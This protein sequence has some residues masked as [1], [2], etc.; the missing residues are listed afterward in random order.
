MKKIFLLLL[1]LLL[2]FTNTLFAADGDLDTTFSTDG[3]VLH[4]FNVAANDGAI[5]VLLQ[6]DGKLIVG[7]EDSGNSKFSI[8]RFNTDG[9]LDTTFGTNGT[10][11]TD[12]TAGSD[13]GLGNM[14]FQSDGKIIQV[15]TCWADGT[16][17]DSC[18]VRYDANGTLDT[19][20][21]SSGIYHNS[22]SLEDALYD[23]AL[24]S[25]GKIL[26]GGTAHLSGGTGTRDF[27]LTRLTTSGTVDTSF[28]TSGTVTTSLGSG[29]D[30]I[31]RILIL[32]DGKILTVGVSS[33]NSN[34]FGLVKYDANG[35]IDT[36]FGT[37]GIVSTDFNGFG[38]SAVS[39]HELSDGKIL[40]AGTAGIDGSDSDFALIKYDSNGSID[41][42]FGTSGQVIIDTGIGA[43]A[44]V[45]SIIQNDG[46]ILIAGWITDATS[47]RDFA[48]VKLN[49]DGTLDTSFG[50]NGIVQTDI[51]SN[52]V[53]SARDMILQDDGK[54]V[55]VG[56]SS[57]N[58]DND[59]AIVRYE[60][61]DKIL[62]LEAHGGALQLD[63]T[64]Y[65][66]L[67]SR[68]D[69]RTLGSYGTIELWAYKN[70]WSVAN[71][72]ESLIS[73]TQ[74]SGYDIS[75]SGDT[76]TLN[77][78][79]HISGAYHSVSIDKTTIPSGWN[80][81][82]LSYNGSTISMYLNGQEQ[83]TTSASGSITDTTALLET[84]IGASL[85]SPL[86]SARNF[87]GLV[88]EV[89]IWN[90]ARSAS[91]I[92]ASMNEQLDGNETGLVAYYNFDERVGDTVIDITGSGNDGAI[93]GNVTRVN[94]LGDGLDFNTSNSNVNLGNFYTATNEL[95]F[96]GWIK[97]DGSPGSEPI[98][99]KDFVFAL[100]IDNANKLTSY[101]GDGVSAWSDTCTMDTTLDNNRYYHVA[102]TYNDT[103]NT[104]KLYVNGTLA[105]TCTANSSIVSNSNNVYIGSNQT[106]TN[107]FDGTISE[108]SMWNKEL[109]QIEIKN[110]MASSLNGDETGLVG[111]WPLYGGS[112][113]I[114]NDKTSNN[115]DGNITGAT[116]IDTAP[117]I[118]GDT[119]YTN[120]DITSRHQMVVENNTSSSQTYSYNGTA[121]NT[122]KTLTTSG[123]IIYNNPTVE[124]TTLTVK[125]VDG[126]N[127]LTQTLDVVVYQGLYNFNGTSGDDNITANSYD[128]TITTNGG[129][130][131]ID[132]GAGIDTVV[133]SNYS[134]AYSVVNNGDGT[135]TVTDPDENTTLTNVEKVSFLDGLN[136]YLELFNPR[137]AKLSRD[138]GGD[139]KLVIKADGTLWGWGDNS[140]GQLLTGDTTNVST[141]IQIGT[142]TDWAKVE[143]TASGTVIGLKTNGI[144]WAW[145]SNA[146]GEVG[147]GTTVNKTVATEDTSSSFWRDISVGFYHVLALK[148]DGTLWAWGVNHQGHLGLGD[149]TDRSTPTQVGTDK[150]WVK[151]S[152]G[153]SHSLALKADGTLYS[154]GWNGAGELG[155]GSNN[156]T[157]SFNAESRN[158]PTQIGTDSTWKYI[159]A[160]RHQS[161]AIRSDN[162]FWAWGYNEKGELGDG[163]T[164]L[165]NTPVQINDGSIL[166][167]EISS[168]GIHTLGIKSD[169]SLWSWGSNASGQL[170]QGD[171]TQRTS[172]TQVGS[173]T[174]WSELSVGYDSSMAL[175]SGGYV[176]TWGENDKN[177]LGDG[178]DINKTSPTNINFNINGVSGTSGDD[179]LTGAGGDDIFISTSGIDTIDGSD[180]NDT[181]VYSSTQS[182]YSIINTNGVYAVSGPNDS[183]TLTNIEYLSFSDNQNVDIETATN[184]LVV[185]IDS[186]LSNST[187]NNLGNIQ[188]E[189]NATLVFD[190]ES[191][192]AKTITL[193]GDGNISLE[194]SSIGTNYNYNDITNDLNGSVILDLK[195]AIAINNVSFLT[196]VSVLK[197]SYNIT[198][199]SGV[200]DIS[201][202]D[203]SDFTGTITVTCASVGTF[204]GS[205]ANE[206]I[207]V[208]ANVHGINLSMNGGDDR[209]VGANWGNSATLGSGNDYFDGAY[210]T[211][212]A[213]IEA[214][215]FDSGDTIIGGP[216]TDSLVITSGGIV[217]D[218]DFTN[219][220][221]MEKVVFGDG[222]TWD[223]TLGAKAKQAGIR[224]IN[225]KA[226]TN[227]Y[228]L[229]FSA[230]T[231]ATITLSIG[232]T[233]A[234]IVGPT[235]TTTITLVLTG[236]ESS[237]TIIDNENGTYNISNGSFD[238]TISNID[239]FN[240]NDNIGVGLST[241]INLFNNTQSWT[242]VQYD[243]EYMQNSIVDNT[244]YAT[245][246]V[247][248]ID[249]EK[250][251]LQIYQ[252]GLGTKI[253]ASA[254]ISLTNVDNDNTYVSLIL[255]DL[256]GK[257]TELLITPFNAI[258]G[259]YDD[260][261]L[262]ASDTIYS[263]D[264]S[265]YLAGKRLKLNTWFVDNSV[266]FNITDEL[267][268]QIGK[269]VRLNANG[270][271]SY[272]R[273][274]L[275]VF[276]DDYS[277]SGTADDN[278]SVEFYG[279]NSDDTIS[280]D[281]YKRL[282]YLE[283]DINSTIYDSTSA[284]DANGTNWYQVETQTSSST[285]YLELNVGK[286]DPINSF[287][288]ESDIDINHKGVIVKHS[289]E[290]LTLNINSSTNI[291]TFD[292]D[293]DGVDDEEIK[294]VGTVSSGDMNIELAKLKDF[295]LT[296]SSESAEGYKLYSK[297]LST[298]CEIHHSD[299]SGDYLDKS[300]FIAANTFGS[301]SYIMHNKYDNQKVLKFSY[302]TE[303]LVEVD[304]SNP[305]SGETDVGAWSEVSNIS[306]ID[307][308]S[309]SA[310]TTTIPTMY[311]FN[312]NEGVDGYSS[313]IGL[314]SSF[315][316]LHLEYRE[317]GDTK[318]MFF[319]N[320][321]AAKEIIEDLGLTKTPTKELS[322][323]KTYNYISFPSNIT[324]CTSIYQSSLSSICD[325]HHTIESVFGVTGVDTILKHTGFWSYWEPS[326]RSSSYNMDE[327][328]SIH[329]KEGLVVKL[330]SA[331]TL[332]IPYNL[333]GKIEN[334][335]MDLYQTGWFLTS[336]PIGHTTSHVEDMV[337]SQ[338]KSLKYILHLNNNA[339][340]VH[341]PKDDANVDQSLPRMNTV[342]KEES[343]WIYVE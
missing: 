256:D 118:Y 212:T 59:F 238:A 323:N 209:V 237:Y 131:T 13:R 213:L 279:I 234:T 78:Q 250:S 95:S 130:D 186:N 65:V 154:W 291:I 140:A 19:T 23:V 273:H 249:G 319:F 257:Q 189:N 203:V 76:T 191:L 333:Y 60:N 177:Q 222:T 150:D 313:A 77:G 64:N 312:F 50:T 298:T 157:D 100:R 341:A 176:Y 242:K 121:P 305:Q 266:Y 17:S 3:K 198:A 29:I 127:T 126:N 219:V 317:T 194:A 28:G 125:A 86:D 183:D 184:T 79:F 330:S 316:V 337:T 276:L 129:N 42:S 128:N 288:L 225:A 116:W 137:T 200:G 206:H 342:P 304:I 324:L 24:Q 179:N 182:S 303:R 270:M 310:T 269:E 173:S 70:D 216:A 264:T 244:S 54:I 88:D 240:F 253:E 170:G 10:T 295:D 123:E 272:D 26:I 329:N 8:S 201:H 145:G 185:N 296:F 271:N 282:P 90:T 27:A 181:V 195:E 68:S 63:G 61:S 124:N 56:G 247:N 215:E 236:A 302:E 55:V 69:I 32:S 46:K 300:Y 144:I 151:I 33:T 231:G 160:G 18:A 192:H 120:S 22:L 208:C 30:Y 232:D 162:S 159:N 241:K 89:R 190:A 166:W 289:S 107:N 152:A 153:A 138:L 35:T 255:A 114:A 233:N 48:V 104:I 340:N 178:T 139:Q 105:K 224:I 98:I 44:V 187:F 39:V 221:T 142:D 34:D 283:F 294:Y 119:I 331:V 334:D 320:E 81:F 262:I 169:A 161:F 31:K 196:K 36:T 97:L 265:Y 299:S 165:R 293:N 284:I 243:N 51:S 217:E 339:W 218:S 91:V 315:N 259:T 57:F 146:N 108:L 292:D 94:F 230:M 274:N 15:G 74:G 82:A 7:G 211:D 290:K 172:P 12:L 168:G 174:D 66:S 1:L 188:L 281:Y 335:V 38:D 336:S 133:F 202:L 101:I 307:K 103:D 287:A 53:D 87:I 149:T 158:I 229:D 117:T 252:S 338:G 47:D 52:S 143:T 135:Y 62:T 205:D 20:F 106:N 321:V 111:Y 267:N 263:T 16:Y 246:N 327:L 239:Y 45:K 332:D 11:S 258:A 43:D 248:K 40:V 73:N 132:G 297:A 147:D 148:G 328:H 67:G 155:I 280:Y 275:I 199:P 41:T 75:Y 235:G 85:D 314:D 99:H 112:G 72:Y 261:T 268:N 113:T 223:I 156:I 58:S 210:G 49:S 163:T 260:G 110:I 343:F 227:E 251:T 2:F 180:G 25:D 136:T 308:T 207:R 309:G 322:L 171:T 6:D 325:Q 4:A 306:C 167:D 197:G 21:A 9:S 115:N 214:S 326:R 286:I 5:S 175:N 122:I 14:I 278:I 164:T 141:P 226:I 84:Y 193:Q 204:N 102:S 37:S 83:N 80:H 134:N 220:K 301:D 245:L 311:K 93:D 318:E 71:A 228:S 285:Q 109:S 96:A 254:D 92:N 277:N